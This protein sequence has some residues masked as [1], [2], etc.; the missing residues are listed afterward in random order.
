MKKFIVF[1]LALF[2]IGCSGKEDEIISF[3]D[4]FNE[5]A[6]EYSLVSWIDKNNLPNIREDKNGNWRELADEKYYRLE[7]K[8]DEK[9][10]L[11]GYYL[12][13][14]DE[15]RDPGYEA[16]KVIVETLGLNWDTF[17]EKFKEAENTELHFEE[18][19]Y[20]DNGYEVV[21]FKTYTGFTINFDKV[22]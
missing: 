8:Y 3:I 13:I 10:N 6:N 19:T 2:L 18:I 12:S 22:N 21:I 4:Q 7:G 5:N 16:G 1:L 15:F 14:K 20:T 9:K 17:E 11:T